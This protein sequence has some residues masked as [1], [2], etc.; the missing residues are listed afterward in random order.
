[1]TELLK[2]TDIPQV[3]MAFMNDVHAEEAELVNQLNELI[4]RQKGG[5]DVAAQI[6]QAMNDW[7]E[8]T[9]AHFE[10]EN[11]LMREYGFPAYAIHSEE[12]DRALA[13][14]HMLQKSWM[15]K[16]DIHGLAEHVQINWPQWFQRHISTMDTVTAMFFEQSGVRNP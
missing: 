4:E 14:L 13:A 9:E 11:R 8:H 16:R 1:M 6:D 3:A 12:H 2:K 10:R 7:V 5:E 15:D